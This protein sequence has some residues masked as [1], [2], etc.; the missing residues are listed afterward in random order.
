MFRTRAAADRWQTRITR[1]VYYTAG[2][3]E[4]YSCSSGTLSH[5]VKRG[6]GPSHLLPTAIIAFKTTLPR[7]A[8]GNE[9]EKCQIFHAD[10]N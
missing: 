7:N 3:S 10:N 4:H 1:K 9:L 5:S 8:A 6:A 2:V